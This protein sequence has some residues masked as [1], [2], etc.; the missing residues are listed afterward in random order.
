[1]LEN[2]NS[3]VVWHRIKIAADAMTAAHNAEASYDSVQRERKVAAFNAGF[4][5]ITSTNPAAVRAYSH[6]YDI[7]DAGIAADHRRKDLRAV[8]EPL[9][10]AAMVELCSSEIES[11]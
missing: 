9:R 7:R 4:H 8:A 10:H 3:H 11:E 5:S 1:M 2:R 6:L